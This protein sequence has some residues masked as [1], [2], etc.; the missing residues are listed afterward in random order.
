MLSSGS[1]TPC[2]ASAHNRYATGRNRKKFVCCNILP[3]AAPFAPNATIPTSPNILTRAPHIWMDASS[4]KLTQIHTDNITQLL[5]HCCEQPKPHRS[6]EHTSELQSLMR[7]SYAV[8]CLKK[9]KQQ[10]RQTQ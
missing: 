2:A 3:Q 1:I 5:S 4:I 10:I 9:K 8:F 7:K 6:E